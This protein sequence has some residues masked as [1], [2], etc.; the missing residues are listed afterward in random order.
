MPAAGAARRA[1]FKTYR[2]LFPNHEKSRCRPIA[3]AVIVAPSIGG[4]ATASQIYIMAAITTVVAG[5]I[6]AILWWRAPRAER[7]LLLLLVLLELPMCALA[8]H[9]VRMGLLD[10]GVRHLL[11]EKSGVYHFVTMFYA[12]LT[13][14][15]AKIWPL[16][17]PFVRRKITR[18]NFWRVALALGLGFGIGELWFIAGRVTLKP[19]LAG[20]PWYAFTGFLNER[21]LV[22]L[23]HGVF[24]ALTLYFFT[25][26]R[27]VVGLALAMV[28]H[29]FG[30]FPI[31]LMQI[32]FGHLGTATWTLLVGL[33]LPLYLVAGIL[34]LLLLIV[35]RAGMVKFVF[36]KSLCPACGQTYPTPLL[37][38][39]FFAKRFERCPYCR[40]WH[41]VSRL[42]R[43]PGP[44]E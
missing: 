9:L 13:E 10:V 11:D 35:G 34:L 24:V 7:S 14:E 41:W 15:P 4:S 28:A 33:F 2:L 18:D 40:K 43:A 5:G 25:R 37:G 26:G 1:A 19:E 27:F 36:G 3:I 42:E 21:L 29:F 30:N 22:C 23:M 16:L 39:N 44:R 32:D 20:L 38:L 17:L 12:P 31:Y 8:F 6:G